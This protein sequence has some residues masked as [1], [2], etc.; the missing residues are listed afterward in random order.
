MIL[1]PLGLLGAAP[2]FPQIKFNYENYGIINSKVNWIPGVVCAIFN[3]AIFFSG[4][5]VIN[6]LPRFLLA[7]LVF[8][9]AIAFLAQH[10]VDTLRGPTKMNAVD[11]LTTWA[12]VLT[13]VGFF[14]LPLHFH[15]NPANDLTRR[16]PLIYYHLKN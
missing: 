11:Y 9:V 7:G 12:I 6:F 16:P 14:Y 3:G 4:V 2:A 1:I 13:T 5:P 8:F 10:L 15:A